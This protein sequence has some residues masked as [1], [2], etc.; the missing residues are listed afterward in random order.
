MAFC[1]KSF[2]QIK[3]IEPFKSIALHGYEILALPVNHAVPAFGYQI[4]SN[5][6]KAYSIR[7]IQAPDYPLVGIIS[8]LTYL[9]PRF[10]DLIMPRIS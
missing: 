6:G 9:L 2:S 7:E 1:R 4:T 3:V 10:Q 8:H 5:N